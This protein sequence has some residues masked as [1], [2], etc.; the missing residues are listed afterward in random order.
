MSFSN[1][2]IMKREVNLP[3][4]SQSWT[5]QQGWAAGR[6]PVELR[7]PR[8]AESCLTALMARVEET[9]SLSYRRTN[10]A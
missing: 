1:V 5:R 3:P 8:L 9:V 10:I 4:A 2:R 6:P 7:P